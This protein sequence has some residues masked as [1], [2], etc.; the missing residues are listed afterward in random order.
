[1]GSIAATS[2]RRS[3]TAS[4]ST[5]S[6]G[7]SSRAA[8]ALTSRRNSG[9]ASIASA[10]CRG[11]LTRAPTT[12][13]SARSSASS[14][15]CV[16]KSDRVP[17]P[18]QRPASSATV[19]GSA[20]TTRARS[21]SRR[22]AAACNGAGGRRGRDGAAADHRQRRR[23]GSASASGWRG[24]QA[25]RTAVTTVWGSASASGPASA[26]PRSG[27]TVA[28]RSPTPVRA[29]STSPRSAALVASTSTT[30]GTSRT[31]Q[32]CGH[33]PTSPREADPT[34]GRCAGRPDP[35]RSVGSATSARARRP[36]F[37]PHRR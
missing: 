25:T 18:F 14:A 35:G 24:V 27:S 23:P 21:G 29:S 3:A 1:M 34:P 6:S 9:L 31:H 22:R 4:A 10:T 37:R 33:A 7:W 17:A 19:A 28:G 16:T 11:T 36:R 20:T 30:V 2:P 5:F 15:W 8:S 13:R 32:Q 12:L 26:S